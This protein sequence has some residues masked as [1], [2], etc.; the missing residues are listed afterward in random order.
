[1]LEGG[2]RHTHIPAKIE[3]D[4]TKWELVAA[5]ARRTGIAK[6]Y[7]MAVVEETV[8]EIKRVVESGED[9]TYNEFI[10]I[11]L[12]YKRAF[13]ANRFVGKNGARCK[14]SSVETQVYGGGYYPIA[15]V[16]KKWKRHCIGTI[17]EINKE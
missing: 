17:K 6:E 12:R 3:N 8:N 13:K 10:S 11:G 2:R 4:M 1:M 14:P 9:V 7:V 5:V 15:R 16:S